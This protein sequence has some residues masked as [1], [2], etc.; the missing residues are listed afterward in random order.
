MKFAYADP[1]YLGQSKKHYATHPDYAGEVDHTALIE[2]LVNDYPDG[3]ALSCH[4][5]S[6]RV[7]LPLCPERARILAWVK[8][9]ASFKP[10]VWIKHA[11]E[12]VISYGGRHPPRSQK[13]DNPRDWVAASV[14]TDP[15]RTRIT[16]T[17]TGMIPGV[18]RVPWVPGA[19]PRVFC[20][21]IF[22]VLGAEPGD[23]LDDL[24]PGS[25]I[26]SRCWAEYMRQR[27]GMFAKDVPAPAAARELGKG[28][29]K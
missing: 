4:T 3:W 10:G 11:W 5:P 17:A 26:V 1:P 12:P 2:R 15:T 8:P 14:M 6:L 7:L 27:A 18:A 13:R 22:D 29:S 28:D 9:F 24:F 25:G 21:W 23:T 16:E 20:Y 19:K